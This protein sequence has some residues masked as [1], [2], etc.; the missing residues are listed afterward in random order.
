M[1]STGPKGPSILLLFKN[2]LV[3]LIQM[4]TLFSCLYKFVCTKSLIIYIYI[5]IYMEE[6]NR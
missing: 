5:Y 1:N 2:N 4:I 6:N 3:S